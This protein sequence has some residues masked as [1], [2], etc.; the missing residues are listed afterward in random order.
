LLS[1]NLLSS[2]GQFSE[3]TSTLSFLGSS[4]LTSREQRLAAELAADV[5]DCSGKGADLINL[6]RS[7]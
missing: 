2:R 1:V 6:A 3:N 7:A 4:T 5:D